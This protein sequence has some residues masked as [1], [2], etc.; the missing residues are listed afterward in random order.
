[1]QVFE[2]PKNSLRVF[3]PKAENPKAFKIPDPR[4]GTDYGGGSVEE[5][6]PRGCCAF[7]PSERVQSVACAK[8]S[9]T[10]HLQ[11]SERRCVKKIKYVGAPISF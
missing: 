4:S 7:H 11:K 9:G 8:M 1:M 10:K 3:H 2:A 5:L 6:E